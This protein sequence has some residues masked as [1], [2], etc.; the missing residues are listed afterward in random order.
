[1]IMEKIEPKYITFEQAEL[2]AK[3][4]FDEHCT[5]VYDVNAPESTE[6]FDYGSMVGDDELYAPEQWQVCEWLRV[7]HGI[8]IKVDHFITEQN[9]IDWDFEIDNVDT[10][11]DEKGNYIPLHPFDPKRSY[12]S[13]QEAYSAAFD[14]IFDNFLSLREQ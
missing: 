2:L 10:D 7:N 8:W 4:G 14:Y 9:T 1:M 12:N 6:L 11:V 5:K 13:P 3:K